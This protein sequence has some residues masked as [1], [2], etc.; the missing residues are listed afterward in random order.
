MARAKLLR[1]DLESFLD[2]ATPIR[3]ADELADDDA[4]A[5]IGIVY[6]F[7]LGLNVLFAV[8]VLLFGGRDRILV[9]FG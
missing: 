3:V 1:A 5:A 7:I 4:A 9:P 2:I 8:A 6:Y